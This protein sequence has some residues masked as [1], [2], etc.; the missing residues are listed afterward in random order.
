LE[1][2]V[3]SLTDLRKRKEREET[4]ELLLELHEALDGMG[5]HVEKLDELVKNIV[6]KRVKGANRKP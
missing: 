6:E 2:K 3:V 5:V 1:N 4:E